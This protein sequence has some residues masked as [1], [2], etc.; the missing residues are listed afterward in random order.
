MGLRMVLKSACLV[1][2][3]GGLSVGCGALTKDN[4]DEWVKNATEG[5]SLTKAEID[6]QMATDA[7]NSGNLDLAQNHVNKANTYAPEYAPMWL[8]NGRIALEKSELE[9]SYR[10]FDKAIEFDPELAE[11]YY[12][13]G[14]VS[15][16][17]QRY[18]NALEKY[19]KAYELDADNPAFYLAKAEMMIELG[20][21]V[22]V[23]AELEEKARYFDQNAAMRAM[24]GHVKRHQGDHHAAAM[25][26]KQATMLAPEDMKLREELAREQMQTQDYFQASITLRD[27]VRTEY[28]NG[29]ADLSRMLA[30]AYVKQDKLREARGIYSE[31]T[32]LDPASVEDWF[33]Q[34]NL[35]FRLGEYPAALQCANRLITLSPDDH[36]G[37]LMAGMCWSK[38]ERI[39]RALSLFDRAAEL[40]PTDTTPLILRGIALQ[41][42][43][44]PAAAAD[45]YRRAVQLNPDDTRAQRLLSSVNEQLR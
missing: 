16:R 19:T 14:V 18:E 27:L 5:W 29:R 20:R 3:V 22:Q 38:R 25:W 34:G 41:K 15:Q 37:Y 8:M 24:L 1:A 4:H 40:A 21:L 30:Q 43:D 36:R 35:A 9:S 10:S 11:A 39:D 6:L 12:Y 17:W 23:A 28:A 33:Q 26:F 7:F 13:Q 42:T 32:H 2:V 44:R 45:A 31:L